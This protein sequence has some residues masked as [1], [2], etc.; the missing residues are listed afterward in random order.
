MAPSGP[1]IFGEVLFDC[2]PDGAEVL[3]G[4]PFNVA[5]HLQSF[6]AAPLLVSRVGDDER[7]RR[8]IQAM[9]DQGMDRGAL[10][11][12]RQRATGTVEIHLQQGQPSYTISLDQAFGWIEVEPAQLPR[13]AALIYH[14]SLALWHPE[15]RQALS[16]LRDHCAAPLFID[17]NLRPPWWERAAVL[18]LLE[19]ASWVKLNDEELE[20]LQPQPGSDQDRVQR[21]LKRYRLQGVILTRGEQGAR[22]F[23][24]D[25]RQ[26]EVKPAGE[27]PVVDTVGAGDGFSAVC[28]LGL[29]R[30][31]PPELMLERAQEFASVLIAQQGATIADPGLYATLLQRWSSGDTVAKP[32]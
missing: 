13:R 6:G 8:I 27:L 20:Q 17:V 9:N 24:A 21:L 11:L 31:W 1:L 14:G 19:G 7:G 29:L 2:F 12:D 3:G 5:W 26:L 15:S 22:L 30:G 16:R 23:L 4:A 25:G 28:I 10:Q 18:S 32:E